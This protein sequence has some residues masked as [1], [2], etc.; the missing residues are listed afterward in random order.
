MPLPI[1]LQARSP[2]RNSIHLW[3]A[4]EP[5]PMAEVGVLV[6][7]APPLVDCAEQGRSPLRRHWQQTVLRDADWS[8]SPS[9]RG[10]SVREARSAQLAVSHSPQQTTT[11]TPAPTQWDRSRLCRT[12]LSCQRTWRL[13][14][15]GT[16]TK[17]TTQCRFHRTGRP[18]R[19]EFPLDR[20][21]HGELTVE[22]PNAA[23]H[24]CT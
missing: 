17:P 5:R 18:Q 2:R 1:C 8:V 22:G 4:D 7:H 10:T 19:G 3:H 6:V 23:S 24:P 20:P 16:F 11:R 12:A 13:T 9:S 15:R 21:L 14:S